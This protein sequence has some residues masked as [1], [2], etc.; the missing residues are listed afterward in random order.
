MIKSKNEK[1]NSH[2]IEIE[3]K[4]QDFVN[5]LSG[6]EDTDTN[7]KFISYITTAIT[8]CNTYYCNIKIMYTND[9]EEVRSSIYEKLQYIDEHI[10]YV[11]NN[12]LILDHTQ[13]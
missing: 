6:L 10:E 7:A 13:M 3:A 11:N 1:L 9:P 2:K 8:D 5:K 4:K 12:I